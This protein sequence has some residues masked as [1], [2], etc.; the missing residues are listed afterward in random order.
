LRQA[1][2]EWKAHDVPVESRSALVDAMFVMIEAT[3]ETSGCGIDAMRRM[4]ENLARDFGRE[5]LDAG[6]IC[7]RTETGVEKISFFE[8]E[9][10]IKRGVL[11]PDTPIYDLTAVERDGFA[12]FLRPFAQTPLALRIPV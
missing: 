8:L 6:T 5:L 2:T 7:Y 12:D 11:E 1:L 3:S 4:V 10:A 9:E